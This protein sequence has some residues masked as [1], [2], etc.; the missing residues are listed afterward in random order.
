[1]LEHERILRVMSDTSIVSL[2]PSYIQAFAIIAAGG[3]AYRK[4]IYQR[5]HEPATDIDIDLKFVGIQDDKWVIEITSFLKNQSLVRHEYKDFQVSIRFL[6]PED[7][8]EDGN[9]KIFYQL[10]CPRSIDERIKGERRFFGNVK[11]INPK[12]EFKH[13]YITY[14]PINA[15]FVWVQCKFSFELRKEIKMNSQRI[16]RVPASEEGRSDRRNV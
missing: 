13:R 3:W 12:Q 5:T 2:L 14:I 11:Y 1:M 6:L 9:E 7:K 8:I 16:F 10:N 15:T 4:F